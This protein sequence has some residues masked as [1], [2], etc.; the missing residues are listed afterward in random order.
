MFRRKN[1]SRR[2]GI[3]KES[4]K[5]GEMPIKAVAEWGKQIQT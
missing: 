5:M 4:A 2:N 3:K 1:Y